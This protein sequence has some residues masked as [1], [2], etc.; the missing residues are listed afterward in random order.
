MGAANDLSGFVPKSFLE[1]AVQ[2]NPPDLIVVSIARILTPDV[3]DA[4][5][6]ESGVE[7][8]TAIDCGVFCPRPEKDHLE[9]TV[10][11]SGVDEQFSDE[12][13][14]ARGVGARIATEAPHVR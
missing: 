6:I 12:R 10:G 13:C 2:V 8:A 9:V 1:Q 5:I 11:L 7:R 3:I 4:F 14:G